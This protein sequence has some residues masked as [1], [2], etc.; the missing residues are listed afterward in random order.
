M[1]DNQPLD[2]NGNAIAVGNTLVAGLWQGF[3]P[4]TAIC[5]AQVT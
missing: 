5:A 3:L 1:Q 4:E 2:K